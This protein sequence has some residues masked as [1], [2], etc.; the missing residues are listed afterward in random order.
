MV[1]VERETA[2]PKASELECVDIYIKS[3]VAIIEIPKRGS[4]LFVIRTD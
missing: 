4:P 1:T 2:I 3:N